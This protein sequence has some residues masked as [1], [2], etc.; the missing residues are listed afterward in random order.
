MR[1]FIALLFDSPMLDALCTAVQSL[2]DA[3]CSGNFTSRENLHL[4]LAFL[5]E[6]DRVENVVQSMEAIQEPSFSI[7][8][9]G[10]GKFQQEGDILYWAGIQESAPLSSLHK[11]L[12]CALRTNGFNFEDRPFKPHLTL[13]RKVIVDKSFDFQNFFES[14]PSTQAII[15]T[16]HLMKSEQ[17]D[18]RPV[19]TEIYAKSL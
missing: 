12:L 4:T 17:I 5:G 2:K 1:L 15:R 6:T 19:Y 14:I 16:I 10:A 8:L 9:Q 3:S 13:G 18:G 11:Q 7:T